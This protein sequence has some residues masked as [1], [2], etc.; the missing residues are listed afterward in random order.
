MV[1]AKTHT[2]LSIPG[3]GSGVNLPWRERIKSAT[4]SDKG[5]R[6][7]EA[8]RWDIAVAGGSPADPLLAFNEHPERRVKRADMMAEVANEADLTFRG[9]NLT[10]LLHWV[11][12]IFVKSW[13]RS[14]SDG[15]V[16]SFPKDRC[17]VYQF[18]GAR[19]HVMWSAAHKLEALSNRIKSSENQPCTQRPSLQTGFI[20]LRL[21]K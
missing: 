3:F 10:V 16:N 14:R 17:R 2:C 12:L 9:W 6:G 13:R 20:K 4:R 19:I 7:L 18:L 5:A 15:R 8:P 1:M 21:M 11:Y